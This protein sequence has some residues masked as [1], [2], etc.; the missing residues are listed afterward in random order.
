MSWTGYR[1]REA[2]SPRTIGYRSI[3]Q[4][5]LHR[6]PCGA[7]YFQVVNDVT[8]PGLIPESDIVVI[9][10]GDVEEAAKVLMDMG[11]RNQLVVDEV[12]RALVG[13]QEAP[14]TK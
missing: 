12:L 1:E 9:E 11:A 3:D 4:G 14:R 5:T 13:E 10:R 6:C 7:N 2:G 8:L